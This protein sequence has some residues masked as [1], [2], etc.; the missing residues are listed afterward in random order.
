MVDITKLVD[1]VRLEV[2]KL[3]WDAF[4]WWQ[5]LAN[6]GGDYQLRILVWFDFINAFVDVKHELRLHINLVH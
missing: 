1:L 2:S 5:Q 4:T 6:H 3:E